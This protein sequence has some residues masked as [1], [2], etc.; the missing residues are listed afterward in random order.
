MC[1]VLPEDDGVLNQGQEDQQH[2]GQQ[3]H[4]HGGHC[5]RHRN[6]GPA[7][8]NKIFIKVQGCQSTFQQFGS[9]KN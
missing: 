6:T 7:Q 3:P 5:V 9:G 2:A 1:H 8:Q 4:L